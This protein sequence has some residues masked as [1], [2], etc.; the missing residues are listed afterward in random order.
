M[1]FID[2]SRRPYNNV[3]SD[4]QKVIDETEVLD[5]LEVTG[6]DQLKALSQP[7]RLS[8]L[9]QLVS[10]PRTT[11]QVAEALGEKPTK[12]YHHVDALERAG[13]IRLVATRPKRGTT[14]KYFRAVARSF[15]ADPRLFA[16]DPGALGT[17]RESAA[18][19]FENA[20]AQIRAL[21]AET[22]LRDTRG[23]IA[24]V[25]ITADEKTVRRYQRRLERL[26]KD[27]QSEEGSDPGPDA[28]TMM[29]VIGYFPVE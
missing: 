13:V 2:N 19:V 9:E 29:L 27:L 20:A 7:L 25:R 17:L 3:V 15:R 21:P 14:E 6:L 23:L 5:V 1:N 4:R 16:S 11:K 18:V 28:E 22:A 24:P 10:E 12:L 26:V 8:I